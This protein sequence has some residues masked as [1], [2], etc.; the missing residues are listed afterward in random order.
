MLAEAVKEARKRV[1]NEIEIFFSGLESK[2]VKMC[3]EL[4][5]QKG[6]DDTKEK[7]YEQK[8]EELNKY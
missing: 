6:K 5:T 4:V 2:C 7:E 1:L 8:I 3:G